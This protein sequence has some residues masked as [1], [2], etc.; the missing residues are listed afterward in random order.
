MDDILLIQ[1]KQLKAEIEKD[2]KIEEQRAEAKKPKE[3]EGCGAIIIVGTYYR[4]ITHN[5]IFCSK[6]TRNEDQNGIPI[7]QVDWRT[8]KHCSQ[9]PPTIGDYCDCIKPRQWIGVNG[10]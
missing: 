1:K 7:P 4:C 6:C 5:H 8:T 3:C 2:E 10:E 9:L